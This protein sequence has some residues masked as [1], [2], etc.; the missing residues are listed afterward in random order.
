MSRERFI[1]TG[2]KPLFSTISDRTKE[3]FDSLDNK[4]VTGGIHFLFYLRVVSIN[5]VSNISR[6]WRIFNY[7]GICSPR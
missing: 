3:I 6:S 4:I 5:E 1:S 7:G 2:R